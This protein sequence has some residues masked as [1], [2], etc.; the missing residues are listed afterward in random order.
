M[1]PRRRFVVIHGPNGAG[2]SFAV[3]R[4]CRELEAQGV[5]VL[6]TREPQKRSIAPT[7][8]STEK[9]LRSLSLKIGNSIYTVKSNRHS[10]LARSLYQI[11][12]SLLH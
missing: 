10:Q 2:K 5:A 6:E 3:A 9:R 1:N 4:V 12:T 7:R 8:K 11:G